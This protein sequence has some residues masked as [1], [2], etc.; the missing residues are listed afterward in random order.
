[1]GENLKKIRQSLARAKTIIREDAHLCAILRIDAC[2]AATGVVMVYQ[3]RAEKVPQRKPNEALI[4]F[5][6]TLTFR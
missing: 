3:R 2:F 4:P 5:P 6:L 1:M